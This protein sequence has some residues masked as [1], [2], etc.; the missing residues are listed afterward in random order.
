LRPAPFRLAAFLPPFLAAL[1]L[2]FGRAR[3]P[4]SPCPALTFVLARFLPSAASERPTSSDSTND[5]PSLLGAR[6][7]YRCRCRSVRA[8]APSGAS[9]SSAWLPPYSWGWR[10]QLRHPLAPVRSRARGWCRPHDATLSLSDGFQIAFRLVQIPTSSAQCE[11]LTMARRSG[12]GT[13]TSRKK[14]HQERRDSIPPAI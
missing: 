7:S 10:R 14:S 4:L 2:A 5:V 1:R 12:A 11:K 9:S 8:S 6:T 3:S 13:G